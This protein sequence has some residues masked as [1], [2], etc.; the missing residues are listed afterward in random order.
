MNIGAITVL[1]VSVVTSFSVK[2]D[3]F[4]KSTYVILRT[5][6]QLNS[7]LTD[8]ISKVK[9]FLQILQKNISTFMMFINL[10]LNARFLNFI[11]KQYVYIII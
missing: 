2:Y 8:L 7:I 5:P 9:R 10:R 11:A 4:K 1:K 3:N 6:H